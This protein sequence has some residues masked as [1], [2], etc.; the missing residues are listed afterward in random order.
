ML[1]VAIADGQRIVVGE[2]SVRK[3]TGEPIEVAFTLAF[4]PDDEAYERGLVTLT[5]VSV[6]KLAQRE[7]EARIAE[8]ERAVHF[9]EMFAGILGHDLRNPLSAITTAAGLL[10]ARADSERIARPARRVVAS[11]N[12]ME[13]MISQLLD[14]TRIRLGGGL[15]LERARVDLAELAGSII[16]ELEPVHQRTIWLH[17]HGDVVGTWDRDRLSQLLS[18]LAA[19]ACQHGE[20]GVPVDIVLDGTAA[21]TV[22]IEVRNSGVIPPDLL[23]IV[24]EPLRVSADHHHKR[25]G[26]SGLGLGLYI[27][28]QIVLSHGGTI[29]I[30]STE[31]EGTRFTV[32][33]P[34]APA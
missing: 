30:T 7:R 26:S 27:S 31:A 3:L 23:P 8:M 20:P 4:A 34:R 10:E 13:R 14:F 22:R 11:A 28:Q 12:R 19:N 1:M 21:A 16:E 25:G 18:N 9:G 33:L 15:P 2:T 32:D 24:F 29:R 17:P 6:Q 5:D